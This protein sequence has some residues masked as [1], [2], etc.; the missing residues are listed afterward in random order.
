MSVSI[1]EFDNSAKQWDSY[2]QFFVLGQSSWDNCRNGGPSNQ[3]SL[4]SSSFK[5]EPLVG[6]SAGFCTP[7]QNSQHA[8]SKVSL[9]FKTRVCMNCF[10]IFWYYE[11]KTDNLMSQSNKKVSCLYNSILMKNKLKARV[12]SKLNMPLILI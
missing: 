7:G 3:S 12:D 11:S 5:Y 9:I 6:M 8:P 4:M 1:S 2:S 10:Q